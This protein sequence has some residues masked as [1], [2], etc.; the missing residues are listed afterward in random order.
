MDMRTG[1]GRPPIQKAQEIN[2]NHTKNITR[3]E[4]AHDEAPKRTSSG[5]H[6]IWLLAVGVQREQAKTV[7]RCGQACR[8]SS[9]GHC[10]HALPPT[11]RK[12]LLPE[13]ENNKHLQWLIVNLMLGKGRIWLVGWQGRG[14]DREGWM[15]P[16]RE[17]MGNHSGRDIWRSEKRASQIK[18]P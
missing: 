4:K 12:C 8:G 10:P 1:S 14:K 11:D 7:P 3:E 9:G 15:G 17:G 18:S 5:T 13:K 2:N 16:A 6:R